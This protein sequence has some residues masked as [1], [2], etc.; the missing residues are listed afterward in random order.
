MKKFALAATLAA[1]LALMAPLAAGAAPASDRIQ[2]AQADVTVKKTIRA[3]GV[4]KKVVI[5]RSG[6]TVRRKVV[7]RHGDRGLHRG[8]RH[9]R[10]HGARHHGATR[11]KTVIKHRGNKTIIKK[12]IES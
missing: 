4:R 11:T 5:K 1:G 7:I 8:W 12:K 2:L 9:S 6:D 10:H 3:N